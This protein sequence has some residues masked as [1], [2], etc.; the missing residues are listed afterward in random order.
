MWFGRVCDP[1][2]S[3]ARD[4]LGF[5]SPED[6]QIAREDNGLVFGIAATRDALEESR[7]DLAAHEPHRIGVIVSSSKGQLRSLLQAHKQY[8][9]KGPAYLHQ[10]GTGFT[11]LFRNFPGNVLGEMLAA[12]YGITGP[13]MNYPAACATGLN[14]VIYAAGL[15]HDGMID[16]A[17]AGSSESS[18]NAVTL[19]SFYNMGAIADGH[20]RPFHRDRHGFNP[21]EGAGVFILE[22]ES[23]AKKRGA[24]ILGTICG[25]D[26]RSDAHHMTAV[27]PGGTV[28]EYA[29]ERTI[30]EAGWKPEDVEYINAHGT[31][32]E[33]NDKTEAGAIERVFGQ[34]QPYVSSL[35]AAIGHLLGASS[36]VELA[37][38]MIAL[39]EDF[40]PPTLLLDIPDPEFHL[41]FVPDGGLHTH[42]NRFMKF[43]YGFGGHIA[44]VAMETGATNLV[45]ATA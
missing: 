35:K 34:R 17:I 32:T 42:I 4:D 29:I 45:A 7:L 3:I 16:V 8:R 5:L 13:V 36:G 28:I 10:N 22:R 27:E 24:R 19:A 21:G 25:Y 20:V 12:K 1:I 33:L 23:D 39:A 31:G 26:F 15:L 2:E 6:Q 41:N 43:S 11:S 44:I 38:I 37:L 9:D 18:G 14:S 30:R 40:V